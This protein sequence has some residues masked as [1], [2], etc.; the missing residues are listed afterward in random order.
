MP[1]LKLGETVIPL[2]P[3]TARMVG[4]MKCAGGCGMETPCTK[5]EMRFAARWACEDC[6]PLP[7]EEE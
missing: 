4:T 1:V 2:P 6:H 7:Q 5:K 3:N